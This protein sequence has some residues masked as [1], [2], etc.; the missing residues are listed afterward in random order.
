V[1]SCVDDGRN[2]DAFFVGCVLEASAANQV[3][4]L[5]VQGLQAR[6]SLFFVAQATKGRVESIKALADA[7]A[8]EALAW[9]EAGRKEQS[10][11]ATGGRC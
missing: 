1:R 2:P 8:A 9:Q 5:G 11:G 4:A 6:L 7:L 10:S 3:R